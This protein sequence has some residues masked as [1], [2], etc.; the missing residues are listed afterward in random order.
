[1]TCQVHVLP[2][3]PGVFHVECESDEGITSHYV[4]VPERL[5]DEIGLPRLDPMHLVEAT[6]AYLVDREPSSWIRPEMDLGDLARVF[7]RYA[8][9]MRDRLRAGGG[10]A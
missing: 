5:L 8:A 4:T 1:M 3:A 10:A 6:F 7:P 9:E 2:Q